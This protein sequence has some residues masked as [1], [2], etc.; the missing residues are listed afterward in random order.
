MNTIT[1]FDVITHGRTASNV[2]NRHDIQILYAKY[3]LTIYAM[4]AHRNVQARSCNRWCIKAIRITHSECASVALRIKTAT[5]KRRI[6][7]SY[8]VCLRL[9][10]SSTVS[11]KRHDLRKGGYQMC[12][13][14]F[15]TSFARNISQSKKK[16]RGIKNAPTSSC[17]VPV[18][19]NRF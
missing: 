16:S 3:E 10:Y 19:L 4:Y 17:K 7:L 6:I 8:V 11:H 14:S 18:V 9:L 2:L 12:V 15:S 1:W 13:L 5:H